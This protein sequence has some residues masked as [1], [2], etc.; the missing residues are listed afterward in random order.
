MPQ[1]MER[2]DDPE[3]RALRREGLDSRLQRVQPTNT[4][5]YLPV[6]IVKL[7][8]TGDSLF[9]YIFTSFEPD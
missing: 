9:S 7:P 5:A 6:R 2:N 8:D 3:G 1:F 4:E